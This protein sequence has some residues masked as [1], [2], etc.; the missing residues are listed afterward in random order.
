MKIKK[1]GGPAFP[2]ATGD[3]L[4]SGSGEIWSTGGMS[5]RDYLAA[6]AMQSLISAIEK[7]SDVMG[8]P[9]NA[10]GLADLML[11]ERNK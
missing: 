8:I 2:E 5:L 6:K 9:Y 4:D 11:K 1:D 3:F 10:Y 7:E